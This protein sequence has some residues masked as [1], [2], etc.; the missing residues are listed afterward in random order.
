MKNVNDMNQSELVEAAQ[1]LND[2]RAKRLAYAQTRKQTLTPAQ[3]A[4]RLEYGRRK[5][6]NEKAIL[7]AAAELEAAAADAGSTPDASKL[8]KKQKK[9]G[10]GA[11][12]SA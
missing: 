10:A 3:K 1:K 7:E 9:E 6:E 2:Q 5:R 12:A 11:Q 8:S 4:K